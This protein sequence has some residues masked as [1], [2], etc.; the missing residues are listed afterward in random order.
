MIDSDDGIYWKSDKVFNPYGK[1][2]LGEEST[3]ILRCLNCSYW[4]DLYK[5]P[6]WNAKPPR[7]IDKVTRGRWRHWDIHKDH[8][9]ISESVYLKNLER[10]KEEMNRKDSGIEC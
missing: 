1:T 10:F 8:G 4:I 6:L 2:D 9:V 3:V 7:N 5:E